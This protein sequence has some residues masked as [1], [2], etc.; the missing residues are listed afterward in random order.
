MIK[1]KKMSLTAL[2]IQKILEKYYELWTAIVCCE[3]EYKI[4]FVHGYKWLFYIKIAKWNDSREYFLEKIFLLRNW[5]E[6]SFNL[7]IILNWKNKSDSTITQ[8]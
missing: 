5:K 1:R 3:F 8:Q 4:E 2:S 7:W 6:K